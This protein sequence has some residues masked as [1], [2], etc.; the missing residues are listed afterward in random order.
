MIKEE[1]I[2]DISKAVCINSRMFI[3]Q[4]NKTD[5]VVNISRIFI[6]E[7]FRK[8]PPQMYK[9]NRVKRFYET[10]QYLD[11]PISVIAEVNEYDNSTTLILVDGYSR[12]IYALR[13]GI[14]RI[15]VKYIDI[16]N[17]VERS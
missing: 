16:N 12:Y 9:V 15:P 13:N 6:P 1:T 4:P 5:E 7:D 17:Y 14:N 3:N 11:K 8:S 10:H 2:I